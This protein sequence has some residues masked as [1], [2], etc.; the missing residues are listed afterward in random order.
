MEDHT[1]KL[2]KKAWEEVLV[3][4]DNGSPVCG[5]YGR[6]SGTITSSR[7]VTFSENVP[8]IIPV[9][10]FEGVQIL[11]RKTISNNDLDEHDSFDTGIDRTSQQIQAEG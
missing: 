10:D 7:N 5:I 3:G 9:S 6:S 8:I 4:Y 11:S 1:R 2:Q